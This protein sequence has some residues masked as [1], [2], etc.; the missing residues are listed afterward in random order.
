VSTLYATRGLPGSGKSTF[1]RAWV[2][3][4]PTNRARVNGDDLRSMLTGG[5]VREAERRAG[6]ARDAM[7]SALLS[8]GVDVVVDNTHLRA[9]TL[10]DLAKLARSV[11]AEFHV[12]DFIVHVEECVRRDAAR[13][14]PVGEDVIRD[15]HRRFLA[16]KALPLPVPDLVDAPAGTGPAWYTPVPGAPRAVLVD[17]DGT[18]ALMGE[19]GPYDW[20]RVGED[21]PNGPVLDVA[22]AL[23]AAGNI[24]VVMSG[25]SDV[26]R[27]ETAAWLD[28]HLRVPFVGPIM[29]PA[30]DGRK[31]SEL[32]AELF[33]AHV[34]GLYDVTAV[35]DDRRQVVD[36]WRSMGLTVLQVAEGEF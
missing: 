25:R 24:L 13:A 20:D 28:T 12:W 3:Q 26:C 15:M 33:D 32:K 27:E 35:L 17:V 23:H 19:R 5:F 30:G 18:L 22:R 14:H 34:R 21:A 11:G 1:A 4:D 7:V 31:D 8:R 10:R 6:A 9:R 36:M 16:G 29:R 2:A